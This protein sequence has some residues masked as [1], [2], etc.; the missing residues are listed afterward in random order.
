M[1][2]RSSS[3]EFHSGSNGIGPGI[4]KNEKVPWSP[5]YIDPIKGYKIETAIYIYIHML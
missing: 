5:F 1:K 2:I 4:K 3:T